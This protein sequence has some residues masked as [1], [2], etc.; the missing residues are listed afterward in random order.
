MKKYQEKSL[1]PDYKFKPNKLVRANL[2]V[3]LPNTEMFHF[4]IWELEKDAMEI[5]NENDLI[6]IYDFGVNLGIAFQLQDDYLDTFGEELLVGK[7]IGGD[8][9]E[10]KKK[11]FTNII[12]FDVSYDPKG[13]FEKIKPNILTKIVF[14]FKK[15]ARYLSL[16][17]WITCKTI[18]SL[19]PCERN[20]RHS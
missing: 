14:R 8:I 7:S 9:I 5:N 2:K 4:N 13:L 19:V 3:N 11:S 20:L 6:K 18:N 1:K 17:K 10:N 16:C 12:L 15:L